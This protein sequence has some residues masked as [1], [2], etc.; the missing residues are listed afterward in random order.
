MRKNVD[1]EHSQLVH[2]LFEK[3]TNTIRSLFER[4]HY[5][6]RPKLVQT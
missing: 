5:K 2:M 3:M 1:V 6:K 4:W